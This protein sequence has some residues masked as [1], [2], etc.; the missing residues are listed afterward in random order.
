VL[1]LLLLLLLQYG[2][3]DLTPPQYKGYNYDSD[4]YDEGYGSDEYYSDAYDR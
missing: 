3:Y 4:P 2:H 1:L